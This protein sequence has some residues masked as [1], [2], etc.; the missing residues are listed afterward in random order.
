[1]IAEGVRLGDAGAGLAHPAGDLGDG[2][3]RAR[4]EDLREV[5]ALEV[6]HDDERGAV[7]ERVDVEDAG[8]VDALEPAGG[9][10]LAQEALHHLALLGGL[11]AQELDGDALLQV[12]VP[13]RDDVRHA[14]LTEQALDAVLAAEH[15][16]RLDGGEQVHRRGLP[17]P[18]RPE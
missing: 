12:Q 2:E 8:D 4:A 14:A 9:A 15:V 18:S 6:L 5:L 16:P 3:R 17:H 13:G 7:G 10:R 1:M 11:R